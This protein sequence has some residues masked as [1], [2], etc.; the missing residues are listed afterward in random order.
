MGQLERYIVVLVAKEKFVQ[1]DGRF[2]CPFAKALVV[3]CCPEKVHLVRG[4][5][6]VVLQYA[7]ASFLGLGQK[8]LVHA[9][10]ELVLHRKTLTGQVV[11]VAASAVDAAAAN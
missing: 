4:L 6:S 11:K 3:R 1:Q 10:R 2:L 8:K 9:F 7:Q 5:V